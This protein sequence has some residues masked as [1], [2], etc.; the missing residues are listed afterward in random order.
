[1]AVTPMGFYLGI[2]MKSPPPEGCVYKLP[3][4]LEDLLKEFFTTSLLIF[5]YMFLY[6]LVIKRPPLRP[7]LPWRFT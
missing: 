7:P 5:S 6:S 1:M 3:I 2:L 4:L